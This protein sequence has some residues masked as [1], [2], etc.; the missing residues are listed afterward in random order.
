MEK[1]RLLLKYLRPYKWSAVKNILYNVGSAIFALFSYT[2]IIPFIRILFERTGTLPHPGELTFSIEYFNNL[3]NYYFSHLV[4]TKGPG[5]ALMIVSLFFVCASLLKNGFIFMANNSMAYIR[6][7]TIRDLRA[8]IYNKVLRLPLSYFTNS[9]KGDIMTRISNDVQEIEISVISSLT[10]IFRDPFTILIFVVYL[11]ITS[12]TLTLIALVLLPVTGFLISRAS[13]SLRA[14]SFVGQQH[15]GRLLSVFEET[16]SGL[17]IINGFNAQEK[18][19]ESFSNINENYS[20]IFKR[21]NR[22]AY[23]ASP[24]SEFLGTIVV[25]VLLYLGGLLAL[26]GKGGMSSESLIVFV[27]IFSQI[28]QPAKNISVAWF[29]IQKGMASIDRIDQVLEAEET[30]TEKPDALPVTEFRDSIV[31][32]DVWYA[33]NDEPVLREINLTIKKGQTVAIVGRSGAGKSTLA[34]LLPRF[35][36][37]GK[38]SILIDG[39]DI[40]DL[41]MKDLRSLM[42]IVSQHPILFNTTFRE[43]IAFGKNNVDQEIIEYA[44]R[45]ANAHDFIMET[46]EGYD[47]SVGESGSK[48][49]GGQRQRISIARAIMANPP[50]LILDEA[51]SALDTESERLVQDAIMKLMKNR[52]SLVIAHRLS[53]IQHADVIIVLDDGRIVETGTHAELIN[54]KDGFYQK[55]RSFQA[56]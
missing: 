24:L 1:A 50:I 30:I 54:R 35:I 19:R 9:R 38:G 43:N 27:A 56:I 52:T 45:I 42:G 5:G 48:L 20:K 47:N 11:F 55:L 12:Y 28:L 3:L 13:R 18:M 46:E 53:T 22:K 6:A 40:R 25:M 23:L 51:T 36:D 44:A 4:S 32:K 10:M 34:D 15:L 33:Y 29:S 7:C 14:S 41:K 37:A 31:F 26:G 2:L 16:L 49:S 21:V 17:R 8:S 39:V